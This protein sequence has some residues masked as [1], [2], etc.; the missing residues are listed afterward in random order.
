MQFPH[1]VPVVAVALAALPVASTAQQADSLS[2]QG[3]RIL[4]VGLGV[5]S[6]ANASAS[7]TGQVSSDATGGVA[8]ISYVQYVSPTLAVEVG[9]TVLDAS[10]SLDYSGTRSSATS[11][12]LV[13][14][15]YSPR[16]AALTPSIRPFVSAA[17]GPYFLHQAATGVGGAAASSESRIGGRVG[18]G[19]R[20]HVARHLA[21]V[22]EGDYHAVGGFASADSGAENRSGLSLTLGLGFA[23]GR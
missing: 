5:T 11:A 23:W 1:V 20:F 13:G 19:T 6:S 15:S 18:V 7:T 2:Q 21:L 16:L 8:S 4:S 12:L 22:V 14:L 9:A 17:I 10:A 3:R